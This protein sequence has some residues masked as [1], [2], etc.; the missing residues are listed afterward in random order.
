MTGFLWLY[1]LTCKILVVAF[2]Y[3]IQEAKKRRT[4]QITGNWPSHRNF[5]KFLLRHLFVN[6]PTAK[7]LTQ[8]DR[9]ALLHFLLVRLEGEALAPGA[10]AEAHRQ[11]GYS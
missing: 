3:A 9:L 8:T 11:F 1:N 2:V 7:N 5:L 10:L 4:F 6:M